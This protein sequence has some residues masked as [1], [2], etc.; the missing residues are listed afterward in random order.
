VL[1][2]SDSAFIMSGS[3]DLGTESA[4]GPLLSPDDIFQVVELIDITNLQI[5]PKVFE[6]IFFGILTLLV[7]VCTYVLGR[8]LRTTKQKVLLGAIFVMYSASI[9]EWALDIRLMWLDLQLVPQI[10]ASGN[11]NTSFPPNTP[12]IETVDILATTVNV[13]S[14]D[15]IVLWRACVIYNWRRNFIIPSAMLV[16]LVITN[17]TLACINT[18]RTV[19]FEDLPFGNAEAIMLLAYSSSLALNIWA[20]SAVALISWRHR[21]RV[22]AN[23]SSGSGGVTALG[24]VLALIVESGVGYI[25]IWSVFYASAFNL[26]GVAVSQGIQ[27]CTVMLI[28]MYPVVVILLVDL[29]KLPGDE[30]YTRVTDNKAP[31]RSAIEQRRVLSRVLSHTNQG[32]VVVIGDTFDSAQ[33]NTT[34]DYGPTGEKSFVMLTA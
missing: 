20:T 7:V 19:G 30:E 23:V 25:I 22:R 27:D 1:Q 3:G 16:V 34:V 28:P 2:G 15:L 21:K 33:L 24:G 29:Y 26:F 5:I 13:I 11:L 9:V 4:G 18:I 8:R 12:A 14:G 31:P 32:S 17:W 6:S 10:L